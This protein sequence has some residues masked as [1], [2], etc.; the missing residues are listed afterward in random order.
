MHRH[1]QLLQGDSIAIIDEGLSFGGGNLG[2]YGI[3]SNTSAHGFLKCTSRKIKDKVKEA[4]TIVA[5]DTAKPTE[6]S[7]S[8]KQKSPTKEQLI[9]NK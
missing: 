8:K 7:N 3:N 9:A 2:S 5:I 1:G 6:Q 4:S